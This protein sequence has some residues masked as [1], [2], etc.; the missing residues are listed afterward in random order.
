MFSDENDFKV[1]VMGLQCV[2]PE[3]PVKRTSPDYGHWRYYRPRKRNLKIDCP[4]LAYKPSEY[5]LMIH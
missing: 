5:I 4:S 3:K 1:A 2:K